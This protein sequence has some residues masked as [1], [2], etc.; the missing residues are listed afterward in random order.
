MSCKDH[1]RAGGTNLGRLPP[2]SMT[3]R[4]RVQFRQGYWFLEQQRVYKDFPTMKPTTSREQY[5]W[6]TQLPYL[7]ECLPNTEEVTL[8]SLCFVCRP[9]ARGGGGV[10]G[11][12]QQPT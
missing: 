10:D 3:M 11:E 1:E 12:K 5:L 9:F 8:D 4:V 7:L 2:H 6:I